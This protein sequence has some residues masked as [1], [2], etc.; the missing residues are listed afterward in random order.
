MSRI[1]G[2]YIVGF[3]KSLAQGFLVATGLI[4]LFNVTALIRGG[5]AGL[6]LT[7]LLILMI[8]TSTVLLLKLKANRNPPT[9]GTAK[10]RN[11]LFAFQGVALGFWMF[12]LAT[13]FY[14]I[15]ITGLAVELNPLGWPLGILGALAFYGPILFF[16]YILLFR[17]KEKVCLYAAIP[18][19][20][21][22][23]AMSSM[24]LIAGA[25]NFQVFVDTA[26]LSV[27]IRDG[28]L[29]LLVTLNIAVPIALNH[30]TTATKAQLNAK[31]A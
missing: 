1:G 23:L 20:V 28:M 25:Q 31:K 14:A 4:W 29:S 18:L 26:A 13:T 11:F 2:A 21:L 6:G 24:N 16:S 22:T 12:D 17:L 7:Y 3:I 5:D 27:S 15:N 9:V 8:P 19:T 30:L 10:L